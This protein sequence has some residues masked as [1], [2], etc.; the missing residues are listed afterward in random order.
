ML[1]DDL[2]GQ[3]AGDMGVRGM[4]EREV[5]YVYLPLIHFVV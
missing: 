4:S 3:D 5:V 1:R 2:D